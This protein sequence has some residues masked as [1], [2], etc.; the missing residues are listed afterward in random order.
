MRRLRALVAGRRLRVATSFLH[1][2]PVAALA[3][4]LW[5]LPDGLLDRQE[6]AER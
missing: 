4:V 2:L 6:M 3:F 1:L 5:P